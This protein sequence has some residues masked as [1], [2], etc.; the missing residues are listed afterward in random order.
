MRN[1]IFSCVAVLGV[2]GCG[3][4]TNNPTPVKDLSVKATPDLTQPLN[5]CNGLLNCYINCNSS[6]PVQSCFDDCDAGATQAGLDLLN[7][8]GDC[9]NTYCFGGMDGTD[10]KGQDHDSGVAYCDNNSQDPTNDPTHPDCNACYN[11]ILGNGGACRAA[12]TACTNSKP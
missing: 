2:V 11:M 10:P 7:A 3:D 8:F 5:G 12:Q 6:N 1:L 9:I 4:N